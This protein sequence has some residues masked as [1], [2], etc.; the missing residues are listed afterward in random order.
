MVRILA[1]LLLVVLFAGCKTPE[2]VE[3]D[4]KVPAGVNTERPSSG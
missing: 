3:R 2:P 4:N 1:I